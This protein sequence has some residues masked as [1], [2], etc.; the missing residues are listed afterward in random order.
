M[1]ASGSGLEGVMQVVQ[2]WA[3]NHASGL[4]FRVQGAGFSA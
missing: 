4:G 3:A 1:G 2:A